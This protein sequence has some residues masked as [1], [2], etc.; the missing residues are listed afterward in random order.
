MGQR[1]KKKLFFTG[2]NKAL[3][4]EYSF[5]FLLFAVFIYIY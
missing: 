1:E 3:D 5:K 2:R 4:K